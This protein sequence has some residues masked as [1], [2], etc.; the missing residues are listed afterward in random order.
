MLQIAHYT[1]SCNMGNTC[2]SAA[3][4]AAFAAA[5][6]AALLQVYTLTQFADSHAQHSEVCAERLEE[7]SDQVYD[8]VEQ[9]CRDALIQLQ[10]QLEALAVKSEGEA[11]NA[12][13]ASLSGGIGKLGQSMSGARGSMVSVSGGLRSPNDMSTSGG[14]AGDSRPQQQVREQ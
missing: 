7:F 12:A 9:A 2:T 3:A 6:P 14:K 1:S 13:G 10:Q 8:T 5:A 11:G 4:H